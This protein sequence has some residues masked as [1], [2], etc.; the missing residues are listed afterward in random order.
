M[1]DKQY[2]SDLVPTY[3]TRLLKNNVDVFA[4]FIFELYSRSLLMGAV[5]V[6]FKAAYVK[7]LLKKADMDPSDVKCYRPIGSSD[8]LL[9][10]FWSISTRRG[11]FLIYSRHTG[12]IIRQRQRSSRSS[13][14]SSGRLILATSTCRQ[15]STRSIM[16]RDAVAGGAMWFTRSSAGLISVIPRRPHAVCPPQY[17]LFHRHLSF[18]WSSA[19][20]VLGPILF[21]LYNTADLL[22][23]VDKHQLYPHMYADDTQ[24]YGSCRPLAVMQFQERVSACVDEMALW[25][26]SNR[27]QVPVRPRSF[28]NISPSLFKYLLQSWHQSSPQHAGQVVSCHQRFLGI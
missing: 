15:R 21:V 17:S 10:S 9:V 12:P 3:G 28:F 13:P 5:P 6:V 16:R 23:L 25:M 1:P 24:T 14:T 26:W 20:S 11:C 22:R 27:L 8:W 4:P 7:P 19:G 18:V 2:T